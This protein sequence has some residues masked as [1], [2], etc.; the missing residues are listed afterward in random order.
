M[1]NNK[2]ENF[3][4]NIITNND[5]SMHGKIEYCKSGQI[6]NF[7]SSIEMIVLINEKLD[8][9]QFSLPTNEFRSW[10]TEVNLLGLKGGKHY[11]HK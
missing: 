11:E 7:R 10:L 2:A 4:L 8:E 5:I 6:R 9:L 1:N 3:K